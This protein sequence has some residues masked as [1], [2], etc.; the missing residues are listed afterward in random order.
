MLRSSCFPALLFL[1]VQN[2]A[3]LTK[4]GL[5]PGQGN[6]ENIGFIRWDH[7]TVCAQRFS[8]SQA[9]VPRR[10]RPAR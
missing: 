9:C 6:R 3:R 7:I 1:V 8:V 2:A 5:H 10:P 4:L